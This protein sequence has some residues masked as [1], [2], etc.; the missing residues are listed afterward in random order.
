MSRTYRNVE[1]AKWYRH[2]QQNNN[3]K[4]RSRYRSEVKEYAG[5][6]FLRPRDLVREVAPTEWQDRH[7]T[8][9]LKAFTEDDKA[10]LK[11]T[12]FIDPWIP[13][14]YYEPKWLI[15]IEKNTNTIYVANHWCRTVFRQPAYYLPFIVTTK[16]HRYKVKVCQHKWEL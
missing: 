4:A 13:D 2:P 16:Q 15:E 3:L 14:V 7:C 8:G 5:S 6:N 10:E 11:V 1:H 12:P 9:Y